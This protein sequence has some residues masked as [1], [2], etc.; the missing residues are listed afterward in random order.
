VTVEPRIPI[1]PEGFEPSAFSVPFLDTNGPIYVKHADGLVRL[2]LRIEERHANPNGTCHGGMLMTMADMQ[3]VMGVIHQ[4]GV[5][6]FLPTINL[7]MDFIAPARIGDWI[8]GK[9]DI[10]RRT[11]RM[12]FASCLFE[13]DAGQ[14]VF[15]ANGIL[16]IPSAGGQDR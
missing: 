6:T 12:A 13:T 14:V 9:T 2:G 15:R 11:R 1:V 7:T 4:C 3:L 16:K 5:N 10:H 8:Q